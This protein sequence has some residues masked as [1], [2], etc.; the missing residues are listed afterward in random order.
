MEAGGFR[1]IGVA[2]HP[3]HDAIRPTLDELRRTAEAHGA[4]VLVEESRQDMAPGV[5][6]FDGDNVDL[7]ITLG[8]DGTLLRG[9]RMAEIA[10]STLACPLIMTTHA[11]GSCSRMR[12]SASSP[13]IRAILTSMKTRS[14]RRSAYDW[15]AS[16]TQAVNP[17]REHRREGVSQVRIGHD[18]QLRDF[19]A[20][21]ASD[22]EYF[23][24]AAHVRR[25][26]QV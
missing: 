1:R 6:T 8:G 19:A 4:E 11:A 16:T 15:I 25:E 10:V 13:S 12:S 9:A 2:G 20:L 26:R 7:L 23:L 5:A 14:G 22:P 17:G 3:R 18:P 21:L 24:G